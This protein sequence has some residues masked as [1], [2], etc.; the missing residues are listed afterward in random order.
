MPPAL[1]GAAVFGHPSIE[2]F[3]SLSGMMC[4]GRVGVSVDGM[5]TT[6][7]SRLPKCLAAGAVLACL[8][9][10]VLKL[11]WL[12]GSTVGLN[13][14]AL[15]RS[16]TMQVANLGT[17]GMELVGAALA[18]ALVLPVGQRLPSWLVQVPMF[19]GTGL[20]GGILVLLPVEMLLSAGDSHTPA[21]AAE[22]IQGWVYAMV[23]GGFAVL[24][25]CLLTIFGRH[26]WQRWAVPGGW[27]RPLGTYA[28]VPRRDGWTAL[29]Q[30]GFMVVLCVT[31]VVVTARAGRLGGHPVM[32]VVMASA[33]A[34][35]VVARVFRAPRSVR[36]VVP[37]MLVY[38]GSA[39][40]AA[41]GLY[42]TVVLAVP[43]PLRGEGAVPAALLVI[44]P[45]RAITGLLGV[46]LITRLRPR[47]AVG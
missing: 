35:G 24:G 45:L 15:A 8:P 42:F 1:H 3:G 23:Y 18:V 44:E 6:Q 16:T 33:S 12:G 7:H 43:N 4:G 27:L 34:A 37:L 32:A 13:D 28:A 40:V 5:T 2:G 26:T 10:L 9:Y 22:P 17:V 31:E 30:A 19:V 46:V 25:V 47:M 38:C 14:L 11:M 36:G 41:W 29:T 21:A 39:A 20:L